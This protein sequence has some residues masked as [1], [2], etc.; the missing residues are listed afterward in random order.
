MASCATTR[1]RLDECHPLWLDAEDRRECSARG[2]AELEHT[3]EVLR[4][5]PAFLEVAL[6]LR[7]ERIDSRPRKRSIRARIQIRLAL[8]NRELRPGLF[9]RHPTVSS[10]GA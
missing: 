6:F 10:T 4:A 2:L 9:V 7:D 5:G 8:E 1:G 3:L